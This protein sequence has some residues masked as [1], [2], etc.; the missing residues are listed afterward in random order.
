MEVL[1]IE[2]G[3]DGI[4]GAIVECEL[5]EIRSKIK[6]VDPAKTMEPHKLI[7][8]V[9]KLAKKFDWKGPIGCAF[10]A[11]VNNGTVL[12]TSRVHESWLDVDVEHLFSEITNDP[13][14]VIRESD[15]IGIAEIKFGAGKKSKGTVIILDIDTGV[16]SSLFHDGKLIP[17]VEL[18][19]VEQ[20]GVTVE[21]RVSNKTRKEEGIT[22]KIWG[23]R[24]QYIL[25]NYERMFHPTL[26]ILG[27]RLG[28]KADKTFPYIKLNTKFK[29]AVFSNEAAIVGAAVY[30]ANTQSVKKD[31]IQV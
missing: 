20:K 17:N 23:R 4:K 25:E 18:G 3:A 29:A 24:L 12:A 16:G 8:K 14:T 13:V 6:T 22:H 2:I 30:A 21:E 9:H 28:K 1:G 15:A 27:G 5:G 26:F 7:S 19:F 11:P 10:P 31:Y